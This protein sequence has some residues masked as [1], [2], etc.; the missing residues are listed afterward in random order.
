MWFT[1]SWVEKIGRVALRDTAPPQITALVAPATLWPPNGNLVPVA[2]SGKAMDLGSGLLSS[3]LEYAVS[4]EYHVVQPA[5]HFTVDG[6]GNYRF[7]VLL[8]ASRGGNDK[9]GRRYTILV[10][11]RDNAGNSAVKWASVVVPH[12]RR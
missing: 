4:D 11:A 2:V 10:S 8:R 7:T 12:D 3:S 9:D 1:E 5:G 6:A